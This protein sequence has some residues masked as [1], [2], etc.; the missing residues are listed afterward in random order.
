MKKQ[1]AVRLLTRIAC[2]SLLLLSG[3]AC[4][5][6]EKPA[7][8]AGTAEPLVS[9]GVEV[10]VNSQYIWRGIVFED[11]IVFQPTVWLTARDLTLSV[12]NN[13]AAQGNE[14]VSG[15]E[16]D[17]AAAY[18][19]SIAG[20]ASEISFSYYVYPHQED[21][22]PTGE[23]SLSVS[24]PIGPLEAST[25][26]TLDVIE[27]PGAYFGE[28]GLEFEHELP[29]HLSLE[30]GASAGWG[31]AEFN[32]AYAGLRQSAWNGISGRAA[33]TYALTDILYI[34]PHVELFHT[35]DRG[36]ADATQRDAVNV[37]GTLGLSL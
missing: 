27:Y 35:L 18:T 17:F 37:G 20:I 29:L 23:L 12:W 31:S 34:T 30:L 22:P 9:G 32:E 13:R 16:V 15:N 7:D 11:H 28:I 26:Q 33:V 6:Q 19:R 1:P 10:D 25:T 8:A 36:V 24:A 4:L 2:A 3:I 5:G 14:F 21:S